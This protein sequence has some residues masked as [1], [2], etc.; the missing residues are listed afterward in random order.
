[1]L[2]NS[3]HGSR[4]NNIILHFSHKMFEEDGLLIH[5]DIEFVDEHGWSAQQ[6]HGII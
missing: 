2:R 1:M 5:I 3:G 4:H 6:T